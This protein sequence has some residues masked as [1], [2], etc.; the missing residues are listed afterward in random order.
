VLR[1]LK[2]RGE[3][4]LGELCR[5]LKLTPTAV[6][7]HMEALLRG[8]LV[9]RLSRMQPTGRPAHVYRLTDRA[10]TDYFPNGYED[11]A[12]S[13]LDTIFDTGGHRAVFDFL[14]ASNE[15][16]IA[17]LSP[18]FAE[19]SLEERVQLVA[20]YFT[21]RGYMTDVRRLRDGKFFLYHQ[22]CAVLNAAKKFRQLCFVEL[23]LIEK[24]CGTKVTRQHYI[25]KNHRICGYKIG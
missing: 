19:K 22:N 15:N 11:L 18:A 2:I 25:F 24:L 12:L 6:R 17:K 10:T 5:A 1:I 4:S 3:L 20:T 9:T 14:V 16:T 7:R 23:K 8:D 13:F 21:Q